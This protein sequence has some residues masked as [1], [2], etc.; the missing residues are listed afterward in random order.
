VVAT[1]SGAFNRQGAEDFIRS[2]KSLITDSFD[3][4]EDWGLII[5]MAYYEMQMLEAAEPILE[6][7]KWCRTMGLRYRGY[8]LKSAFKKSVLVSLLKLEEEA[9]K[10]LKV[11]PID[12]KLCDTINDVVDWMREKRV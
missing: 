6:S 11:K 5:D 12:I 8:V 4:I 3:G 1:L 7:Y 10:D 2:A 9:V